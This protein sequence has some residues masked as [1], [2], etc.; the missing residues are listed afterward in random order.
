[1]ASLDP[2]HPTVSALRKLLPGVVVAGGSFAGSLPSPGLVLSSGRP[3]VLESARRAAVNECIAELVIGH[4]LDS[5]TVVKNRPTGDRDWPSGF[6]GSL[7]HKGTVVLGALAMKSKLLA[8]GVDLELVLH[9]SVADIE[10]VVVGEGLAPGTDHEFGTLLSLS[11]KESIYK[12]RIPLIGE[13]VD[14]LSIHLVWQSSTG[15]HFEGVGASPQ[16]PDMW[17]KA[18]RVGQ[19]L[20]SAAYLPV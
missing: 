6:V 5:E 18:R 3:K 10:G 16:C 20:L 15:E 9:E 17:F 4:G 1:M 2:N 13:T 8:L 11:V 14:F 12:A 7:T 19:W